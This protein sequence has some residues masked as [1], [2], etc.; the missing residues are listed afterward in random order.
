MI[1]PL[2]R[3]AGAREALDGIYCAAISKVTFRDGCGPGASWTEALSELPIGVPVS[4][5]LDPALGVL[6]L[7]PVVPPTAS[8]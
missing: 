5:G 7:P 1:A 4:P 8:F 2:R 6:L 3:A